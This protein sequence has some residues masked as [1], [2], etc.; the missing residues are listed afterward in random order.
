LSK[1][2]RLWK[3]A[4]GVVIV[5]AIAIWDVGL[6]GKHAPA[7]SSAARP[8]PTASAS[9]PSASPS[10]STT[11]LV[12]DVPGVLQPTG[13]PEFAAT[14]TGTKLDSSIWDTCYPWLSQTGCKNFGNREETEW[15][16]PSQDQVSGGVL[17]LVAKRE[18]TQGTSSNNG[19]SQEYDCRSGMITSYPG[20]RFRYG[21]I[22]VVARIPSS[23]GLWPAL[24]LDPANFTWPPE[25]DLLESWGDGAY[26]GSFFHPEIKGRD[27]SKEIYSPA[28]LVAGWHT[29]AL[30]WTKTQMTWLVDGKVTMTVRAKV[31]HE[32][33]IFIADLASYKPV[34]A[35]NQCSGELLIRSVEV[36][37]S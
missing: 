31:P 27:T 35:L 36:W 33:M 12:P 14:F 16:L 7:A 37:K 32:K 18:P 24:W 29:F 3:L 10:A 11:P 2:S 1:L 25:M 17:H 8:S 5:L 23:P 4:L 30:S 26:A 28:S 22:Q 6:P 9:A 13:H 20:L 34:G 19:P 21:Y 15:Y